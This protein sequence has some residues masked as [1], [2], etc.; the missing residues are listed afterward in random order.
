MGGGLF[1][2]GFVWD[3]FVLKKHAEKIKIFDN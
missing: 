2:C 3:F 1:F